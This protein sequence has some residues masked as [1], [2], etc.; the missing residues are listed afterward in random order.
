MSATDPSVSATPAAD[1]NGADVEVNQVRRTQAV[2]WLA[3]LFVFSGATSLVYE[4]LWERQLHLVVGTSQVAVIT[5]LAAFMTGLAIGGFVAARFADKVARPLVVYAG[6]E[7]AIGLYA[8][9]YPTVLAA[10][11][12]IYQGFWTTFHPG[13]GTFAVFQFLLI[14]LFLLPPTIC[15]GATLPLLARFATTGAAEAGRRVGLLYGANTMGAVLGVGMAGF[16]LLP[17]YG[18]QAT[19]WL[20]AGGNLLLCLVAF[21]LGRWAGPMA[22]SSGAAVEA[23][24]PVE[25]APSWDV[26]FLGLPT[27]ALLAGL[28]SLVL[29]VSFFRLM[30][31]TLGGSAYA[32]SIMLLAFLLGIAIGGGAGGQLADRA[33]ARGGAARAL[34][35]LVG[36]Q[37]GVAGLVYA[38]MYFY[39]ELP[40]AF[41]ALY[42]IVESTPGWL[43]P[44]KL[45][46]AV[47]FML[48]P[49]LLMGA[50][51]PVLVRVA[52]S[53]EALGAPVGRLYGW[54]T[55]GAIIGAVAGGLFLL[56]VRHVVGTVLFAV[57]VN[58]M[59]ALLALRL[60]S[61]AAGRLPSRPVQAGWLLAWAWAVTLVHIKPPPWEP[62]LMTAG[63]YKYVSDMTPEERTR[64]GILEYAVTP[65]DLIFYDE[66]L[67]SVVTVARAQN[68][69]NIWLANNGKVDAS[70]NV[71][72]PTQVLVAHL[73]FLLMSHPPEDVLVIGLASGIT[74]GSVTLQPEPSHIDIVELEP[75]IV[76]ASHLFD[77]YNHR[78]LD[79]ARV[80]LV[81]NDG[82]NH[83]AL[84]APG[85][86]DLVVS[87]PS[88][89]WLTG[90]SNLFTRDFFELGK[91]R[92]KEGGVWAQWV[93][94]Y[95]MAPADLRTLLGTFSD[96]YPHVLMFST[97][98]DAD[99]VLVGSDQPL[100]FNA[101]AIEA[102]IR[103]GAA[104]EEDLRAIKIDDAYDVLARWQMD[105]DML[106]F[107]A[108]GAERNTDD[109]MRIEYSA[110][111]HLHEDTAE[112]NFLALLDE[113]GARSSVPTT[114]VNGKDELVALAEAYGEREDYLRALV[115][116]RLAEDVEPG[117]AQV[118]TLFTQYQS[119]F[120]A[121]LEEKE[122]G[123]APKVEVPELPPAPAEPAPAEPAPTEP[124]PTE[125]GALRG[126]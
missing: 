58:L 78:P 9:A 72:M 48:P 35:V 92:L 17:G 41:V 99:L 106:Q 43:W 19:T 13:P 119:W 121:Q 5:V 81:A 3:P 44:A 38:S 32:F 29:E 8:L 125:D 126:D 114:A 113:G 68:S 97:I 64:E 80:T 21:S 98:E 83:V 79:D 54:N 104:V 95:G 7:G 46:L 49:A 112:A 100:P 22:S 124:L 56:P 71:D 57:A 109:N 59:A 53:S 10:L 75:A 87:E 122:G 52:A 110:P 89:P 50:T 40:F 47:C 74:A 27:I 66:G 103:V 45:F 76:A 60:W 34:G 1:A 4:T 28:S 101:G 39:G 107:F 31:L 12:P 118:Q 2:F 15:M 105:R 108:E 117:D 61:R 33:W 115:T 88:N 77:E 84:A 111:L 26:R 65:Y 93:Q 73:P 102:R 69:G 18:L 42:G 96:T 70:T 91:S 90:V 6:L 20:T 51:F 63:M 30:V 120:V 25:A 16:V 37:L 85:S 67:S 14:G 62:L 116:L 24:S 86:Y 36:L 11:A 23:T 123:A 82:R 55:V 94:M